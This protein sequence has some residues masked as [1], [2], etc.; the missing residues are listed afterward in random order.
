METIGSYPVLDKSML[1]SYPTYEEWK[2][3]WEPDDLI[4]DISSY[5]TYEEWKQYL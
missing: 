2:R 1:R 5:P 4:A 3:L